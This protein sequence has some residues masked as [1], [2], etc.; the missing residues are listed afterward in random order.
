MK[1]FWG[2]AWVGGNLEYQGVFARFEVGFC[3]GEVDFEFDVVKAE[4]FHG[5]NDVVF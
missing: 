5:G 1:G 2:V 3:G 4:V